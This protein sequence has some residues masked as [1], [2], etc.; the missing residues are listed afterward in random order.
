MFAVRLD[1]RLRFA[2]ATLLSIGLL[3]FY[4]YAQSAEAAARRIFKSPD[5]GALALIDAAKSDKATE[6]AA[7]FG[8][9][10]KD[11]IESG[12]AVQ[13]KQAKE[14][15]IAACEEKQAI[16]MIGTEKAVIVVGNDEFPFPIPLV[17]S[18]NGW[19]F[20][21]ELGRQEILDRRV[22]KNELDTIKT[23]IAI[24][25]AQGEYSSVDREGKGVHEYAQKFISSPGKRDG[26]YWPTEEF[27]AKEPTRAA[28]G[29]GRS[30][31]I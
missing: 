11:W 9:S 22:G 20:D 27:G 4:A 13:D 12:D 2:L 10:Y 31:R 15:F 1:A 6:L 30:R 19:S 3:L 18:A 16:E 28:R 21:A 17:K 8:P 7:I 24:A 25:D 14:R 23:L 29:R 5:E 26:L